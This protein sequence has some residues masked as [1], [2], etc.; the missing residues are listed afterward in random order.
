GYPGDPR[1]RDF[2]RDVGFDLDFDYVK[3]HL[4]SAD[5]R[6][7]TGLKYY[8]ITGDG[9]DKQ[10]YDRRAALQA[11]AV[12]AQ[13]FLETRLRQILHLAGILDRP[14]LVLSPYDAE[15]FG[16]WWYEGP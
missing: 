8:R 16:H 7:F 9:A 5:E 3:P 10:V 12:H 4:P 6:G 11:A 2:Y 14:A 13:H 1:Y 15:L